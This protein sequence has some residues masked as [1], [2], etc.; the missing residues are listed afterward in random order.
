MSLDNGYTT[1]DNIFTL[2][3][4]RIGAYI[5]AAKRGEG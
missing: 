1:A 2:S 3:A 5:A 4:A